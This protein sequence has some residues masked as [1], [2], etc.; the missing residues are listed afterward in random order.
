MAKEL[1]IGVVSRVTGLTVKS[2]RFYE[3]AGLI[4]RPKRTDSGY[5]HFSPDDVRRLRLLRQMRLLG[6]PLSEIKP[7]VAKALSADCGTFAV[8]LTGA[9][10]EQKEIIARRIA[11]LEETRGQLEELTAHLSHCDCEPGLAVAD[12]QFCPILDEE[13][14][15]TDGCRI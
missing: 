14:G 9:L 10:D 6:L 7:V 1:S 2:I 11:E 3:D 8:E 15:E 13:G 12:C 4:P 5:R